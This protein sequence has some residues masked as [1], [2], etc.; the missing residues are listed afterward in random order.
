MSST[1]TRTGAAEPTNPARRRPAWLIT[2]VLSLCGTIAALQ[3]TLVVPLL[4]DFPHLLGSSPD[5]T[6]WLVTSTLLTGAVST[7][8]V[9]RLADMVGKR[10]MILVCL[11]TMFVGSVIAALAPDLMTLVL[12]RSL[13]GLGTALIPV[14]ISTLRDE[15][16]RERVPAAVALMSA[17]LGIGAGAGLPLS[18]IVYAHL[19]WHAIFWLSAAFGAV[20][21][22]AI[23]LVVP[24]SSVRTPGT[25]DYGGALLL[26][27]GLTALLLAITK[28]G[29][30]GWGSAPIVVLFLAA[31][32]LFGAWV[33]YELGAGQPLVDIRTSAQRS[34]LLTNGASLMVGLSMYCN[35][36]STTQLLQMPGITGYGFHLSVI[37]A[38]LIMLP[39]AASMVVFA[40]L[41]TVITRRW[42]A[43]TTLV[44]GCACL[45]F[46]YLARIYLTSELWQIACGA[47]V[48][49]VGTSI[50]YAATPM[51]IMRSVPISETAA[52]NGLNALLRAIGA[53]T[54]S[55]VVAAL[56]TAVVADF[57]GETHPT[58]NAFKYV[59]LFAAVTG[60][61][62]VALA[63]GIP[64]PRGTAV[65]VPDERLV[66]AG[67]RDDLGTDV[68]ESVLRGIVRDV[69]QR[70][71]RQAVVTVLRADGKAVDWGRTDNEGA[72]SIVLPGAGNYVL[73]GSAEGWAPSSEVFDFVSA[74]GPHHITLTHRRTLTGR[75]THDGIPVDDAPLWLTR[76]TGEMVASTR[77]DRNGCY[78]FP[79]PPTGRF[80]LTALDSTT[81][82]TR[83]TWA[84]LLAQSTAIDLEF[85]DDGA[86]PPL[87]AVPS[88]AEFART[89]HDG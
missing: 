33:P 54:A 10:R 37:N 15:L 85:S 17:T 39:A 20:L 32:A 8:I 62:G 46:G 87:P 34:V 13:Q 82:Q 65:V 31:I 36:L 6:S 22:T 56:L 40:P 48:T 81:A 51:L 23:F 50:A 86:Q 27:G 9:A 35:Q 76:P 3:Q 30:W 49:S 69:D 72:Y 53:S 16:P 66:L 21:I 89:D 60:L 58:L 64:N 43:K 47:I 73:V 1:A 29:H 12:G 61:I 14:G 75:V 28:G 25:F 68:A 26:S 74:N 77:T 52:A 80:I 7:P 19:G 24:E 18:G 63:L 45:G 57:G 41:S 59:F 70:P 4:P 84:V 67:A 2:T 42:S 38:G 83:T 11:G 78:A 55:A 71:I 44:L 79:A 88:L 5:D